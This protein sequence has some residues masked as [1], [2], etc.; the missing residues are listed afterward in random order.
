MALTFIDGVH[1]DQTDLEYK[2]YYADEVYIDAL[3]RRT[4]PSSIRMEGGLT[5]TPDL[6]HQMDGQET[7]IYGAAFYHDIIPSSNYQLYAISGSANTVQVL[8]GANNSFAISVDGN[9]YSA[10]NGLA[11]NL[12]WYYLEIKVVVHPT[13][14]SVELRLNEVPIITQS[15]INTGDI[16]TNYDFIRWERIVT[17]NYYMQDIYV[18]DGLGGV[19]D[20][21]LG[22][23]KIDIIRPNASGTYSD[24]TPSAG[25]NWENVDEVPIDEDV[26]YNESTLVDQKD[27]YNLENVSTGSATIFG[28]QQFTVMRKSDVGPYRAKQLLKSGATESLGDELALNDSY[29]GYR[30]AFDQNP[31]TSTAWTETTI[32]ALESGVKT[33]AVT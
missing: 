19:N 33:V 1:G 4:G 31:N 20:D 8:I 2:Y 22:D 28:I 23:V 9:I 11:V 17:T 5:D 29:T 6:Q 14:G 25:S 24:F 13:A 10:A 18:C 30:R 15:N 16:G 21:F 26:T 3:T 12:V 27:T 32:N 7:V